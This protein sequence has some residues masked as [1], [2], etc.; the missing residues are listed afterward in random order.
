MKWY[1]QISSYGK[2][3]V[4]DHVY[5]ESKVEGVCEA[6]SLIDAIVA[7]KLCKF[8]SEPPAGLKNV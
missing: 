8:F 3:F 7:L 4:A 5:P 2:W 6:D 1:S